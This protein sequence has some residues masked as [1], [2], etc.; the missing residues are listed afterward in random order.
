MTRKFTA[1]E[2]VEVLREGEYEGVQGEVIGWSQRLTDGGFS[3]VVK[4]GETYGL[5]DEAEL[6]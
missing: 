6:V 3:Y 2:T 1:R 4:F 5:F